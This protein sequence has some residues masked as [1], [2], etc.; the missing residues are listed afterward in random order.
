MFPDRV[1]KI[2]ENNEMS[3]IGPGLAGEALEVSTGE[4]D[5]DELGQWIMEL[6]YTGPPA[7]DG[8]SGGANFPIP[9]TT[10]AR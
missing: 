1:Q 3:S 4:T 7:E 9:V 8:L 2:F 10:T 5:P 6:L